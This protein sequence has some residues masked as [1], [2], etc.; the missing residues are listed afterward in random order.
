MVLEDR[1]GGNRGRQEQHTRLPGVL[2]ASWVLRLLAGLVGCT[3]LTGLDRLYRQAQGDG[4][5]KRRVLVGIAE[6]IGQ[7]LTDPVLVGIYQHLYRW[8]LYPYDTLRGQLGRPGFL[9]S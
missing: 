2:R 8:K 4:S 9:F 1:Q 5:L 7:H 3:R 6:Q